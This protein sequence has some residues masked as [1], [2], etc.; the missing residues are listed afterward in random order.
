MPMSQ[1][2]PFWPM[3]GNVPAP[4]CGARKKNDTRC[5]APA[6]FRTNHLGEGPCIF[7]GGHLPVVIRK[8]AHVRLMKQLVA[9]EYWTE[10]QYEQAQVAFTWVREPFEKRIGKVASV[11]YFDALDALMRDT[12][13][14]VIELKEVVDRIALEEMALRDNRTILSRF[15][16]ERGLAARIAKDAIAADVDKRRLALD[17]AKADQIVAALA[18]AAVTAELSPDQEDALR[19]ALAIEMRALPAAT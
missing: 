18:R 13:G 12:M 15:D 1:P 19:E 11:S 4:R 3:L 7:H 14:R 16:Q 6:G 5:R 10:E 9:S 17:E 8:L 2:L